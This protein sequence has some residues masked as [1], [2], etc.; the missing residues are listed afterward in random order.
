M[1]AK[2]T[3]VINC[4]SFINEG[5][6]SLHGHLK[7]GLD[8]GSGRLGQNIPDGDVTADVGKSR[9]LGKPQVLTD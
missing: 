4:N 2:L 6:F 5:Y 7:D 3:S 1:R 8:V 9:S